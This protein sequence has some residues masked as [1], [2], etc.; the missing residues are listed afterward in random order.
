MRWNEIDS[1]VCS[2][3]RALAVVG[4][5]WTLLILRD[6]FM[7]LRRFDALQKSLGITRHRLSDR[8]ARLVESG[9]LTKVPYQER[10]LRHEYRLSEMGRELYPVIL[11]LTHWGDKWLDDGDGAPIEHVHSGCGQVMHTVLTCSECGET[12]DPKGVKPQLGTG[13]T[14]KINRGEVGEQDAQRLPPMLKGSSIR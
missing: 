11:T 8:L 5:R 3:A 4:D 10:P 2:I 14:Q 12:L 9:V 13:I 6:C 1:Q 7:G